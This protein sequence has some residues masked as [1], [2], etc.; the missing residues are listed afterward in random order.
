MH[1]GQLQRIITAPF[2]EALLDVR[3]AKPPEVKRFEA[4]WA[5]QCVGN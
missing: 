4:S 3:V 2:G 1:Y 5:D